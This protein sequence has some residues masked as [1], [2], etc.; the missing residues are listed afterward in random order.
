[1]TA[2]NYTT[3]RNDILVGDVIERLRELPPDWVDCVVTSPPYYMLRDY[4]IANQIG[5]EEHVDV[6]VDRLH[7]VLA[8]SARVLKENGTVWLNL[9]DSFS[10][11]ASYGAPAKGLLCAPERLLLKLA[12]D[13]W[14]VRN[15]VVWAKPNPMPSSVSDR[16]SLTYEFFYLLART[17]KYHFDLNAIRVPHK[18]KRTPTAAT[19][20]LKY[21]AGKRPS[22][23]GPLAGANDGLLKARAEGRAGHLLGKNPGDVWLMSTAG[24]KGAHFATFPPELIRRPIM[25]SCPESVCTRCGLAW[26]RQA[27]VHRTGVAKTPPRQRHVMRMPTAWQT[28]RELGELTGCDCGTPLIPGIVLDPFMG[29]GTT[30][31]VAESLGRDWL[32]IE[33]N[34]EYVDLAW[35]RIEAERA[36]REEVMHKEERRAA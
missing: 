7:T 34:P 12:G 25:A 36:K 19:G 35:K 20:D 28:L 33:L 16:L 17:P 3:P 2:R 22:W 9:G 27:T 8:E 30:A 4:G 13:G 6:W 15:K 24:Y 23:A 1:M 18:S 31:V 26:K 14:L 29:S 32:G 11:H 5:L 10:R 21:G